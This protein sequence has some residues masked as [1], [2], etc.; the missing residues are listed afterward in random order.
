MWPAL[1]DMYKFLLTT[2]AL[3]GLVVQM[4]SASAQ[5]LGMLHPD[6]PIPQHR[7]WIGFGS[8]VAHSS[9]GASYAGTVHATYV[10]GNHIISVRHAQTLDWS[11]FAVIWG[12]QPAPQIRET[13]LLYGRPLYE[14]G[15][16]FVSVGAGLAAV[17]QEY[18]SNPPVVGLPVE[19]QASLRPARWIGIG[20]KVFGNANG[21][22]SF[23]GG[24]IGVQLGLVR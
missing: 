3:I 16:L 5:S 24:G 12:G 14:R 4:P 23:A 18:S 17:W 19:V 2:L 11:V 9:A 10:T 6:A 20:V 1:D 8:G 22:R 13:G 15:E 21:T 7:F